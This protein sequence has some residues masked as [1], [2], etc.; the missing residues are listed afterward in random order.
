MSGETKTS[1]QQKTVQISVGKKIKTFRGKWKHNPDKKKTK[2][3]VFIKEK[4][5]PLRMIY[6]GRRVNVLYRGEL[7]KTFRKVI[8]KAIK[9]GEKFRL[10]NIKTFS[11][12][13]I[14]TKGNIVLK[15][16]LKRDYLH[17]YRYVVK[18]GSTQKTFIGSYVTKSR[19]ADI[20]L[21]QE[22]ID[23]TIEAISDQYGSVDPEMVEGSVTEEV[24][25]LLEPPAPTLIRGDF[26]PDYTFLDKN[27]VWN[28][29]QNSCFYDYLK[30]IYATPNE[31]GKWNCKVPKV[32]R[33]VCLHKKRLWEELHGCYGCYDEEHLD[34]GVTIGMIERFCRKFDINCY[35]IDDNEEFIW[36][37]TEG[38]KYTPS[39]MGLI[40]NGHFSPITDTWKR[41]SL[42][43]KTRSK[44]KMAKKKKEEE[45]EEKEPPQVVYVPLPQEAKANMFN[46]M[47]EK[48]KETGET[49]KPYTLNLEEGH[50]SGFLMGDK[51]YVYDT[52]DFRLAE[53]LAQEKGKK[54]DAKS[55]K[56]LGIKLFD[57]N[58]TIHKAKSRMSPDLFK[59]FSHRQVKDRS[60]RGFTDEGKYEEV[61]VN[62]VGFDINKAYTDCVMNP[63]DR[64]LQIGFNS[65][66]E[67]YDPY[68]R[69]GKLLFKEGFYY[70][71]TT[72]STLFHRNNIYSRCIVEYGFRKKIIMEE[73]IKYYLP[74]VN[75]TKKTLFHDLFNQYLEISK[76]RSI[77]KFL[78]NL[79]TGLVGRSMRKKCKPHISTEFSDVSKFYQEHLNPFCYSEAIDENTNLFVF[80]QKWEMPMIDNHL[81]MYIQILDNMNIRQ[82]QMMKKFL[83]P[84][85]FKNLYDYPIYRKVDMF[86][87][88]KQYLKKN[89]KSKCSNKMGGYKMEIP[90]KYYH[91]TYK[92][93]GLNCVTYNDYY[94]TEHHNFVDNLFAVSMEYKHKMKID[95]TDSEDWEKIEQMMFGKVTY[96][97]D[98]GSL[99]S[100]HH[101]SAPV[102]CILGDGGTGKSHIIKNISKT[103]N[104]LKMCFINK[105]SLNIDGGTFHRQLGLNPKLEMS[106][107]KLDSIVTNYDCIICD[108][109]SM[110]PAWAWN[111][112][113]WLNKLTKLPILLCGDW[114]QVRPVETVNTVY[115]KYNLHPR[116]HNFIGWE[117]EL[118]VNHRMGEGQEDYAKL[119]HDN[120]S[121][122]V[123]INVSE[124]ILND[125]EPIPTKN[126]TYL[127]K[128]RK[129]VNTMISEMIISDREIP[130]NMIF[131]IEPKKKEADEEEF[132]EEPY[133]DTEEETNAKEETKEDKNVKIKKL[134]PP[135]Q[136]IRVF[137][138]TPFIARVTEDKGV[139]LFNNE[140]F[141][142]EEV[143]EGMATL[144]SLNRKKDDPHYRYEI[145]VEKLQSKFL[146]AW[147]ITTHKAQGQT[148]KEKIRIWDWSYMNTELR[149]TAMSRVTRRQ[150]VF[151]QPEYKK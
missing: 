24:S 74:P 19:K 138:G 75:A 68:Y 146:V 105:A 85:V 101:A 27:Q 61:N 52:P 55:L 123:N 142:L 66:W 80:G 57:E 21:R 36:Y 83:K 33:T 72:D 145:E 39:I 117:T 63:Y 44:K 90:K 102:I 118:L 30:H 86:A 10:P 116:V 99:C 18:I 79:T 106:V 9:D 133:L 60:H 103:H 97:A 65:I 54:W 104:A 78:C 147:A 135:T 144:R 143:K 113:I 92:Y 111:Y 73:D 71:E 45:K 93:R 20:E 122:M 22:E 4:N 132:I 47:V 50:I 112:L 131:T 88:D 17:R 136:K 87:C 67:V 23:E 137:V 64:W 32:L 121:Q 126:I 48:I 46:L 15:K 49:P 100:V 98:T 120:K 56:G 58:K 129:Q 84:H 38:N 53:K 124:F 13:G 35:L 5:D 151:I 148:I 42:V 62:T 29:N 89:Y 34:W 110:N 7:S 37:Y 91:S 130:E 77:G 1:N 25:E 96:N 134:E 8:R 59:L 70:V 114:G 119:L 12:F 108:E 82:Y 14:N 16:N 139:K 125:D 26:I 43:S 109:I 3:P 95:V 31:K 140:D 107:S 94:G 128:T 6:K 141:I 11:K 28:T 2:L 40:A 69:N 149:Y 127:N 76:D 51:K 41:K 81:P 150:D 115:D